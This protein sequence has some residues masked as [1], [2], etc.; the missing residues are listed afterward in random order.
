MKNQNLQLEE[1]RATI[2]KLQLESV[3]SNEEIRRLKEASEKL[4][5][6]LSLLGLK[7]KDLELEV[8]EKSSQVGLLESE[9][10]N[11]LE[12]KT[13]LEG[14]IVKIQKDAED[15]F[16]E[17]S[18]TQSEAKEY[19]EKVNDEK[20]ALLLQITD[21]KTS[22]SN[23]QRDISC[24]QEKASRLEEVEAENQILKTQNQ[25]IESARSSERETFAAELKNSHSEI[26]ELSKDYEKFA[27]QLQEKDEQ[28][29]HM[30]N[31]RDDLHG[32]IEENTNLRTIIE[33]NRKVLET[34]NDK[35][36]C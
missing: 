9:K 20:E 11:L 17:T 8:D 33:E 13:D 7:V 35:L 24:I 26:E 21:L 6:D 25:E 2:E 34:M 36:V 23:L 31:I 19:K 3:S 10:K 16:A 4:E 22:N 32:R 30:K 14:Q 5:E 12:V 27:T 15:F 28:L 1:A 29:H 18:K